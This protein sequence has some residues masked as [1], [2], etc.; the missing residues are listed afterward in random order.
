MRLVMSLIRDSSEPPPSALEAAAWGAPGIS[1]AAG[2]AENAAPP[3]TPARFGSRP[4]SS[5][6]R[7]ASERLRSNSICVRRKEPSSQVSCVESTS[8]LNETMRAT[9]RSTCS[10]VLAR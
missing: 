7:S 9:L 3:R 8:R 1:G 4:I 10:M 2:V 6:T 5:I